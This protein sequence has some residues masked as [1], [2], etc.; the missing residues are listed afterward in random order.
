MHM[1]YVPKM[2]MVA[3]C[4]RCGKRLYKG[5]LYY[6]CPHCKNAYFCPTCYSKTFGKCPI[7]GIELVEA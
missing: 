2:L 5:D 6:K 1:A 4:R 3:R 7:C